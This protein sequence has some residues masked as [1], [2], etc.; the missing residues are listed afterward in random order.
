MKAAFKR[1][2]EVSRQ[3]YDLYISH[4]SRQCKLYAKLYKARCQIAA[5]AYKKDKRL[6]MK[7]F[8]NEEAA[9]SA[10]YA[11]IF[12]GCAP[13]NPQYWD[14]ENTDS[15]EQDDVLKWVAVC[16]G[17]GKP[18]EKVNDDGHT[19]WAFGAWCQAERKKNEEIRKDMELH[20]WP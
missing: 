8:E 13:V 5:G 15:T 7:G 14:M 19:V 10:I 9:L 11:D 16:S 20:F 17:D 6:W 2:Y 12:D 4:T 18:L 3:S 1:D